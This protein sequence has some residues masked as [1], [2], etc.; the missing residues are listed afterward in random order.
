MITLRETTNSITLLCPSS[1]PTETHRPES[2]AD[3]D[4]SINN[5]WE[6]EPQPGLSSCGEHLYVLPRLTALSSHLLAVL[7]SHRLCPKQT[8]YLGADSRECML[9]ENLQFNRP[10]AQKRGGGGST[11]SLSFPTDP[12]SSG[13]LSY[14]MVPAMPDCPEEAGQTRAEAMVGGGSSSSLRG[15]ITY[16]YCLPSL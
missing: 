8:A 6:S 10:G 1:E 3:C 15:L 4:T 12:T 9:L 2:N 5:R 16:A 13:I 11:L 14:R 7:D